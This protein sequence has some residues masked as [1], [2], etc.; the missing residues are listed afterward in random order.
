MTL[1]PL[2]P[3]PA[4]PR[5][6]R[7]I[8]AR[9]ILYGGDYN[10]EQ[11]PESV[12]EAD[13]GLMRL[14][15]WNVATLPVFG[16]A[17]LNPAEGV[18]TFD[19]LDRII[20]RLTGAG[21]DL[22][23]ATATASTPAWVDQQYPDVLTVDEQGRKR[24]HGNRH[25]FCP[26]SP[27][28]RRLAGALVR[29]MANRYGGHAGLRLWHVNNEYG[30]HWPNYCYCERCTAEF[31]SHLE[32][33]YG[34]LDALNAAWSTAF[35]GHT[36]SSFSQIDPPF[37]HGEGSIQMLKIDWR[38]FQ[39]SSYLA[40]FE[41]EASI[42]RELTP[43]VPV[44]TN[45]MGA[46]FALDYHDWAK[47]IDVV[48][49]DSYPGSDTPFPHV[50]F[51]H[52][53]MRGLRDGQPF[54]LMEQSPSHQNWAP[55]CRLKPP[56]QLRLQ[57]YQAIAHG[58]ESIMYF[59]W[60]KSRGGIEKLHGA[61][62]EHHGRSDAR[63]FREA[64]ALGEELAA[65]GGR[66]LGGRTPARVAVLFDWESWWALGASSGPSR[67]LDYHDQ[68]IR[69]YSALHAAGIQTDVVGPGADLGRY[70]VVVLPCAYVMRVEQA[71]RI[72]D[73]IRAGARLVVTFFSAVAD[74]N[75]RVH[76]G[77]APGPLRDV[78]GVTVEEYDALP[79][80]APQSVRFI[81]AIDAPGGEGDPPGLAA[82]AEY[83]AS[84]LCER[85]WLDGAT[86]LATYMRDF[87]AGEPAITVNAYGEGKAYYVACRL[88]EGAW[89]TLL[90]AVCAERGI[91]SP[92]GGGVA[93]AEGIEV[94]VRVAPT[95]Q[96]LLYL[97]NHGTAPQ[98]VPLAP[99]THVD[100]LTGKTFAGRAVVGPREVLLLTW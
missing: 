91:T 15:Q 33:R 47:A 73:R 70:D 99:G 7:A 26:N 92:L 25:A 35:W 42:L 46:F 83:P 5:P 10:P 22:C 86:V 72:A 9:Q 55:Y 57:S 88:D 93:P 17:H 30:G 50:A 20:D 13:A 12:R 82:L 85:V 90:R 38:R 79:P 28:Y 89:S 4:D 21:V 24:P 49:W 39:S 37:S 51:H 98:D 87:Y 76:E 67:D 68:A 19:W 59:Q 63:V 41:H 69:A 80:G 27:S 11:W 71:R 43:D 32:R 23:L 40:C 56:G 96:A 58:A 53:L 62:V 29:E 64:S 75:D 100:L 3:P 65:L 81:A 66:T 48:S 78:L 2:S 97:L 18:Y 61:V 60:R 45:F 31:R 94:A 34:G 6:P 14:A 54:V 52:A 44:T 74:E 16:W 84:L 36:Y 95:G 1:K 77:G 8:G